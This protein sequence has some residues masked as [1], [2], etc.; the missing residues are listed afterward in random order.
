MP[1]LPYIET[2]IDGGGRLEL[3]M[4]NA[5][6]GAMIRYAWSWE[7]KTPLFISG[8]YIAPVEPAPGCAVHYRIFEGR[9]GISETGE[10]VFPGE[11]RPVATTLVPCTQNRDFSAYVWENR[12]AAVV[13]AVRELKPRLL[14]IG[15]SITHFFGGVPVDPFLSPLYR[16]APG[17]WD[18]SFGQ[19]NPVNLG[20]GND[21]IENALWRVKNG[22]L[23]GAASDALCVVLLGTNNMKVNTDDE[24]I[25]GIEN[26]CREILLRLPGGKILLQGIYPR[27][28]QTGR[29]PVLNEGLSRISIDGL[30]CCRPGDAI[31]AGDGTPAPGMTHD[32]IHPTEQV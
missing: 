32:G 24:I 7:R 14:F 31:D 29:V 13:E 8:P 12:H 18:R 28:T 2:S 4:V 26:L 3:N 30:F 16:V 5:P 19:W 23:D 25:E 22:E 11:F 10:Y 9:K 21:R 20:F 27:D 15:D 17:I 1:Q 6:E